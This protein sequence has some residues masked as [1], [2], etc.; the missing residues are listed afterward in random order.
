MNAGQKLSQG[1]LQVMENKLINRYTYLA[2]IPALISTCF[3][4]EETT[5]MTT[6]PASASFFFKK[7]FTRVSMKLESLVVWSFLAVNLFSLRVI[8]FFFRQT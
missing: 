2:F 8:P 4:V 1:S 5:L 3:S 7:L 6:S